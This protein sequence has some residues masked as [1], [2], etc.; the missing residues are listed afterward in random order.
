MFF[1]FMLTLRQFLIPYTSEANLCNRY[2]KGTIYRD[3]LPIGVRG[4]CNWLDEM[5][6]KVIISGASK[7]IHIK[8]G[9]G[10]SRIMFYHA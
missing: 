8:S 4:F 6:I 9:G 2:E 1:K 10:S 3:E 7:A 5:Q